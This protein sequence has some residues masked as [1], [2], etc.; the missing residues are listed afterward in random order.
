MLKMVVVKSAE[1]QA[2][3]YTKNVGEES[4]KKNSDLYQH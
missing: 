3:P 4:F 1:N 2:N